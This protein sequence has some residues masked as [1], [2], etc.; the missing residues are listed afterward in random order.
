MKV[1]VTFADDRVLTYKQ[2]GAVIWECG[3]SL[4]FLSNFKTLE[5]VY[6]HYLRDPRVK[7]IS[8]KT[9]DTSLSTCAHEWRH[10]VGMR[11]EFDY[12]IHC[13][14]KAKAP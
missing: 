12:C 10:Y 13:D 14:E 4:Q 11:E 5:E 7:T 8:M 9:A 1:V 3:S 6:E 2:E